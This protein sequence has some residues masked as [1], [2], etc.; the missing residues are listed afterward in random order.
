MD[1]DRLLEE[2]MRRGRFKTIDE[3]LRVVLE[4]YLRSLPMGLDGPEDL[5]QRAKWLGRHR[6]K[7][8]AETAALE[9]YLSNR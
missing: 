7:R 3:A 4:G 9:H 1:R 6:S 5:G 2:A 8:E